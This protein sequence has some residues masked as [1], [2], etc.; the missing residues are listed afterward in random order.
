MPEI[1]VLMPVCIDRVYNVG[2]YTL[3]RFVS[4]LAHTFILEFRKRKDG[5]VVKALCLGLFSTRILDCNPRFI[6]F[7]G[8]L[9]M[10]E[11][12]VGNLVGSNPTPFRD[13]CFLL[14]RQRDMETFPCEQGIMSMMG[15]I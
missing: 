13:I 6:T 2:S 7:C 1:G 4:L 8:S 10:A 5:R 12:A 14:R 3:S 15:K 11:T 9:F